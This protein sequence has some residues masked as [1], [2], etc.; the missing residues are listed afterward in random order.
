MNLYDKIVINGEI[1]YEYRY[2]SMYNDLFEV[3]LITDDCVKVI[4]DLK[5]ITTIDLYNNEGLL[6]KSV[7]DYKTYSSVTL[8]KGMQ[9]DTNEVVDAVKVVFKK[10]SI[11]EKVAELDRIVNGK[12]NEAN[13]SLEEYKEHKIALLGEECRKLIHEGL[14]VETSKGKMHFTYNYDDQ[15][16]IKTLFDSAMLV[17]MDVPYH[18]S[19]NVCTVFTWEDAV[20]IYVLLEGNLLY[21]TTYCNALNTVIREDLDS[22]EKIAAIKYGQEIPENRKDEMDAALKVGQDLMNTIFEKCGLKNEE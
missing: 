11:S 14:D 9:I 6:M 4:E 17:K 15:F 22:K 21:H 5:D 3:T 16:N 8:V 19:G 2:L 13:M 7:T 10:T 20:K 1:E 12:V 18:S